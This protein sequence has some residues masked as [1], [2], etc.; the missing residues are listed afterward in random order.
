MILFTVT[1]EESKLIT[2]IIKRAK[3]R[4]LLIDDEKSHRMDLQATH[5]NGNPL[6]FK[7]FLEAD[8][9]NFIH[10]FC[11]IYRHLDRRTGKLNNFFS[12][13]CSKHQ[14]EK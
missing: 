12:P 2:K 1:K 10:D 7:R 9:F 5:A 6:D 11:G 14:G 4:H 8:D 3:Q 13:R